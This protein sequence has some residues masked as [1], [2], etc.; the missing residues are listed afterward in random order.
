V[1]PELLLPPEPLLPEVLPPELLMAPEELPP[2][3]DPDDAE[4]VPDTDEPE[5][6]ADVEFDPPH[7]ARISKSKY[8]ENVP[9]LTAIDDNWRISDVGYEPVGRI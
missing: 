8:A 6:L 1:L 2:E 3:T 4:T 7:A 5:A 9:V